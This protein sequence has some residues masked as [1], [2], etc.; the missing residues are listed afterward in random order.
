MTVLAGPAADAQQS[1]HLNSAF[2]SAARKTASTV[3][4]MQATLYGMLKSGCASCTSDPGLLTCDRGWREGPGLQYL[5]C[6]WSNGARFTLSTSCPDRACLRRRVSTSGG[7]AHG[8]KPL[9][10]GLHA[11]V[12]CNRDEE[13]HGQLACSLDCSRR[14]LT[15]G[16]SGFTSPLLRCLPPSVTIAAGMSSPLINTAL[17]SQHSGHIEST[18]GDNRE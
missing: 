2:M 16:L 10:E 9:F 6:C 13:E 12:S 3:H 15:N 17:V 11:E 8:G 4:V 5:P 7:Q 18:L 14:E 1:A